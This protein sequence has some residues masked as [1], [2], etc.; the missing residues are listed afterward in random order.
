MLTFCHTDTRHCQRDFH[1]HDMLTPRRSSPHA[2]RTCSSHIYRTSP[3]AHVARSHLRR[4]V[5][6]KQVCKC[7]LVSL[8]SSISSRISDPRISPLLLPMSVCSPRCRSKSP[9]GGVP[10]VNSAPK[11]ES[12][13]APM[14]TELS[15]PGALRSG[16]GFTTQ[17]SS[18]STA[19]SKSAVNS[20]AQDGQGNP[21]AVDTCSIHVKSGNAISA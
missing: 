11:V 8:S 20:S 19:M 9:P 18:C 14:S 16:R 3:H 12:R 17:L 7:E 15:M 21:T 5:T 6:R 1:T 4:L 10:K 13:A 2:M